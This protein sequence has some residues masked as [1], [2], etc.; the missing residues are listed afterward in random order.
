MGTWRRA[1]FA[2]SCTVVLAPRPALA[3]PTSRLTYARGEG[4]E[5]CADESEVR[6]AVAS[7]LGYDPFFPSA[8]K[9]IIT[10]I[11][12]EQQEL[13]A[14]VRLVD[15]QGIVKGL[16]EFKTAADKC[17]ELVAT[18]S[19]AISIAIDPAQLADPPH[20][21]ASPPPPREDAR[22]H[23]DSP[24]PPPVEPVRRP[25]TRLPAPGATR[26]FELRPGL[27]ISGA[28]GMAPNIELGIALSFGIKKGVT[29]VSVEGRR[30]FPASSAVSGG[31]RVSSSM[32][33]GS[34]VPCL[35]PSSL[36][37]C[38]VGSIG[39]MRAEGIELVEPRRA[40]A[41]YGAVGA[42]AGFELPLTRVW[43]MRSHLDLLATWTR[44][45]L[46]ID[47]A[48]RWTVPPVAALA[49][50]GLAAHFP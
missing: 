35:H 26:S 14:T 12:R 40:V 29:S 48:T 50:V 16:R 17:D 6:K 46:Q 34:L 25:A 44:T 43:F 3:F 38:A 4:A 41:P 47:G 23:E 21:D 22:P 9:T 33:T 19:L 30:D 13:R 15:A 31:G 2:A 42:R 36:F 10:V 20:I 37:V 45:A 1:A 8:D 18:L 28:T 32:W 5:A 7:R 27:D 11:A 39:T 24:A 49:A